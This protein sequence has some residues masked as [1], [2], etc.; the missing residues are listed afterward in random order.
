MTVAG[1]DAIAVIDLDHIAIAAGGAGMDDLAGA[2]RLDALPVFWRKSMPACMA[3]LPKNG[4]DAIA[5]R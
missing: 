2:R 4:I 5:E 3:S 1:G